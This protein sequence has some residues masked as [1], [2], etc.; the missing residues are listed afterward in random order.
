MEKDWLHVPK[1]F[2]LCQALREAQAEN[3]RLKKA[4]EGALHG[5]SDAAQYKGQYL[6]N[7]HGDYKDIER[8]SAENLNWQIFPP[9]GVILEDK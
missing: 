5:W 2:E 9:P 7:K 8:L 3:E 6:Y 4:L 1:V